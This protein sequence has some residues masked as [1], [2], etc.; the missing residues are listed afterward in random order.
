[1]NSSGSVVYEKRNYA[2]CMVRL[3]CSG[4]QCCASM[5]PPLSPAALAF[6]DGVP[7][8]ESFG[9]VYHSSDGGLGQAEHVFIGGNRL[10]ERWRA[11][12]RFAILETGFGLGLNFLA[13]WHAW[14]NDHQHSAQLHYVA[15]EM[16]PFQRAD[17]VLLHARWPELADVSRTLLA[18]WPPLVPGCHRLL[19]DQGRVVLT[20]MF[21]DIRDCIGQ[22]DG[23]AGFDAF[24]LDG[25]AP[26]KNP[27]MWAPAVLARLGRLAAPHATL[28]TY[29]VAAPVRQAL[30]QAGF[31][32]E[33]RPGFGRK[34]DMLTASFAP[35][36]PLT[37][38]GAVQ[39]NAIV[40]GAGIAGCSISERLCARGWQVTLVEQHT[41]VA[42]EISGNRAG[43]VMPLLSQDDNL[44]SRLAR[45]AYLFALQTW[46]RV[47]GIGRAFEGEACGVL[48][49]PSSA[50][51]T[52]AQ[53]KAAGLFPHAPEFVQALDAHQTFAR[54]GLETA[55][56]GWL[57]AQGGWATPASLCEALLAA[58]GARL[59]RR[60][61]QQA[62]QIARVDGQW[63]VRDE[64]GGLIG[65]A[66]HLIIASGN[67]AS[68]FAQLRTL[69]LLRVRG[70]VTHLREGVIPVLPLV[71]C[72]EAYLTRAA[73]GESCVGATFDEDDDP[74]LRPESERANLEALGRTLPQF[75]PV[76]AAHAA[77]GHAL[78]G[79]V[80]F[81]CV[82]PDRLPLV[83][84][85]PDLDAAICGS[86]LR[87][88]PRHAGLHSLLAY[89]SRGLIWA[90]FCAELLAAML[91]A[92]PL[93]LERDLAAALDPARFVLKAHRRATT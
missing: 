17:L 69:P 88:V 47:G 30:A 68:V 44:T 39:R 86:R 65:A 32:C 29:S 83:G 35:R 79:R 74:V 5:T 23:G 36:W 57:F 8:A 33:K 11:R 1:M 2:L 76:L 7:Y 80:G 37:A 38:P 70:Q 25:F 56:G 19:L 12:S 40:V 41:Q 63:Q 54:F 90:P 52:H 14:R 61:S 21:G 34:P 64:R 62:T 6:V 58:C 55:H 93:P 60:F 43:I 85:L 20:L 66:A 10:A 22:I 46:E 89:G 9:D 45:A 49:V 15:I 27:D 87:D 78:N 82:S 24:Y 72:G 50:E 3:Q 92:E 67:D 18:H 81:R 91:E 75:A 26:S 77:A 73:G 13:T 53:Q 48:Q 84:A 71:V 51:E 42:Q 16:H 4:L 31:V 59:E 28:A